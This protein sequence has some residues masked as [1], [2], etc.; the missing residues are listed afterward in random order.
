[1]K[2]GYRY[3][4]VPPNSSWVMIAN[5]QQPTDS[6]SAGN[7]VKSSRSSGAISNR[8]RR[9]PRLKRANHWSVEVKWRAAHN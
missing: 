8:S 2:D 1:M 5:G 6:L 4:G 7:S 9:A 3:A